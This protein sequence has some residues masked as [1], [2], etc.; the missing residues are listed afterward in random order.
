MFIVCIRNTAIF[1]LLPLLC[2]HVYSYMFSTLHPP[3]GCFNIIFETGYISSL[4][5]MLISLCIK[6]FLFM[7]LSLYTSVL[8]LQVVEKIGGV[9][10][11]CT[12][13]FTWHIFDNTHQ[14]LL[15]FLLQFLLL[16]VLQCYIGLYY[17]PHNVVVPKPTIF[18]SCS[19][20]D[21]K[22]KFVS[23]RRV[24]GLMWIW[25]P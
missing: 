9:S 3:S 19:F 8:F 24:H 22:S 20:S 12:V 2:T 4:S 16:I 17:P 13:F 5:Y 14:P 25:R 21:P 6:I 23:K 1:K 15:L 7:M 10:T 18:A 11:S